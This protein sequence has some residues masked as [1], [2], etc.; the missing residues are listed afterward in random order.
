MK[1]RIMAKV[2]FCLEKIFYFDLKF[3]LNENSKHLKGLFY[4]IL[5]FCLRRG[6]LS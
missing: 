1:L 3:A 6:Y 5:W 4:L 2:R